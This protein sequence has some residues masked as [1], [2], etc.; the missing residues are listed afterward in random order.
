V[1]R[2]DMREVLY[3]FIEA[4]NRHDVEALG[5][6]Y[7]EDAVL[8][9][10]ALDMPFQGLDDM[11]DAAAAYFAAF[12]D[13]EMIVRRVTV[14]EDR[15][16]AEWHATA[17]HG[18]EFMGIPATGRHAEV[19]GCNV[20]T[21]GEDGLIETAITYWDVAAL[22]HQLGAAPEPSHRVERPVAD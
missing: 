3:R 6:C 4:W 8:R 13:V 5:A 20:F 15:L 19:D 1:Q 16:V 9:D 2:D 7:A 18:G 10:I 11:R 14:E 21:I 12:P 22:L 17:T